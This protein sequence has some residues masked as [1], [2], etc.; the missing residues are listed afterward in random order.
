MEARAGQRARSSSRYRQ[1][2]AGTSYRQFGPRRKRR[3][4]GVPINRACRAS[5]ATALTVKGSNIRR[6]ET[7]GLAYIAFLR[8]DSPARLEPL[9]MS[10]T[11]QLTALLAATKGPTRF[12]YWVQ[13]L[14][15]TGVKRVAEVGVWKGDFA[16]HVLSC[17]P[18]I[19]EYVMLDPWRHLGGWNKPRNTDQ[20]TFDLVY[21]EAMAKTDFAQS[22]RK[23]L[24]G[25]TMEMADRSLGG[26]DY[27]RSIWQHPDSFEPTLISP[28]A[29]NYIL[30]GT[31][32]R[33]QKV[34]DR[35]AR[36]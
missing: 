21:N 2:D 33:C 35:P 9:V 13:I 28:F 7:Q 29:G 3:R 34:R 23:I 22:R 26:D 19:E 12:D 30:Y 16:A 25:T 20:K 14:E 4:L 31:Q 1:D 36:Q 27:T 17:C 5:R 10:E 8:A 6:S 15:M 24:R 32:E 11:G 18:S